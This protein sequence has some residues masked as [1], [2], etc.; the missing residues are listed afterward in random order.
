MADLKPGEPVALGYEA[1]PAGGEGPGVLVLHAWWGL[2]DFIRGLCDRLAEAGFV[3]VAPDLWG[4]VVSTAI[5]DAR[6]LVDQHDGAA[7]E[8]AVNLALDHLHDHPAVGGRPLGALGF[9]FGAAWAL[10]LSAKRPDDIRAVTVFYGS[11]DPD[12]SQS[13]AA[14]QG[15]FAETDLYE[16]EEYMAQMEA[17]LRA[18]DRPVTIYR[19]PGTSHWFC[20]SDRPD[21]YNPEAADLAWDRTITFLRE[22]LQ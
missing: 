3:A 4:G 18:A 6:S 12:F 13:Q 5:D 22:H 1:V 14:Y 7:I 20:E 19:Y 15:H 10:A 21:A 16:P 2:N 8:V 9:S 11:Y 17:A